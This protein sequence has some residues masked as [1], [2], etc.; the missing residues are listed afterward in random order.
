MKYLVLDVPVLF[1]AVLALVLVHFHS[2]LSHQ[3]QVFHKSL[4]VEFV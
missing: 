2:V 1:F 4:K 3:Q